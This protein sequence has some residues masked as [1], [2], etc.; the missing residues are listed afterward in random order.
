MKKIVIAMA[1]VFAGLSVSA[2]ELD[3]TFVN[4]S[5]KITMMQNENAISGNLESGGVVYVLSGK[6]DQGIAYIEVINESHQ[7]MGNIMVRILPT[8]E[9]VLNI[10]S[11]E[12]YFGLANAT[13]F[14]KK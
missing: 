11:K 12:H 13:K 4:G 10:E 9:M 7:L 5:S 3:G 8:G 1:F 2:G 14:I 6:V